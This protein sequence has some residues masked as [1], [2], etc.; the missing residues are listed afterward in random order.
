MSDGNNSMG[1]LLLSVGKLASVQKAIEKI[2][3]EKSG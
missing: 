2:R 1:K 3:G